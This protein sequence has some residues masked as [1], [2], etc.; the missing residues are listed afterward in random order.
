MTARRR[1]VLVVDDEEA[2]RDI[3]CMLLSPDFDVDSAATVDEA[4]RKLPIQV[5]DVLLTDLVMPSGSGISLARRALAHLPDL[6]VI[7]MTGYGT[8]P[9]FVELL[10]AGV[11]DFLC[12]PFSDDDLRRSLLRALETRRVRAENARLRR[13][14]ES[15]DPLA[16]LVGE[17]DGMRA[18]RSLVTQAAPTD[19]TVLITGSSGTGKEVVARAI[20]RLS[21]RSTAP[22]VAVHCGALAAGLVESELFGHSRGAFTGAQWARAG[23]FE[24]ASSGTIF[25]DEIATMSEATQVRL[26]RV[27]Q[28][29]RVMRVGESTE[30]PVD[31]RVVAATNADLSALVAAGRFRADLVFR[32]DV[33]PI[34]LPDFAERREDVPLL[35]SHFVTRACRRMRRSMRTLSQDAMRRLVAH[36][37]PGNVRPASILSLEL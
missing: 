32:L 34:H 15:S 30:R 22:F 23:R 17:S 10:H 37:W 33:L 11:A 25:L 36:A 19:A 3:A 16:E 20:H 4:L 6:A 35:A 24:E 26:L 5:P 18:V 27:L 31:V 29:G 28:E 21:A 9:D 8:L 7:V 1:R 2:M 12:K 13:T 14:L